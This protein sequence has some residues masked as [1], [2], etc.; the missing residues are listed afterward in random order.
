MLEK[1]TL[2]IKGLTYIENYISNQQQQ[3]LVEN[4]DNNTYLTD[5]KRR[6][7][8]YGF[9]Y[10][11]KARK[12]DDSFKIGSLPSWLSPYSHQL[13]NEALV[14]KIPDQ[15]IVNEYECGQGIA[16]HI[17]C[18]TCFDDKIAILSTLSSIVLDFFKGSEKFSILLKPKSLY[19]FPF[20][21]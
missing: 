6:V 17:D 7:Q 14:N 9:K 15:V 10:D 20:I 2:P 4:I 11:Y 16:K 5:L 3:L 1:H 13:K 18:T 19:Q 8:H 21:E 12:I